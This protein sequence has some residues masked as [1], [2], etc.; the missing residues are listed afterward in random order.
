M[1]DNDVWDLVPLLEGVK[2]I[3]CKW[4]FKTKTDSKGDVKRYKAC[5]VTKDF[6]QKK[7]I[8]YKE[9]F[10]LVSSK[11]SFKT[12]MALVAHFILSYNSWHYYNKRFLRRQNVVTKY[13]T[14]SQINF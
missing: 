1:K 6:T 2:P 13:T 4:I 9:T 7:G 12:I 8:D 10:P 3:G 5:L 14:S 11:D